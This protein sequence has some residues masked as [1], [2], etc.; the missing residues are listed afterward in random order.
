MECLKELIFESVFRAG[1]IYMT[2]LELFIHV[3]FRHPLSKTSVVRNFFSD[4]L[5][6]EI[7]KGVCDCAPCNIFIV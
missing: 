3:Y 4:V 7:L 5:T 6:C 2:T 1:S